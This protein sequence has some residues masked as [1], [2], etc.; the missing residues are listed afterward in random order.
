MVFAMLTNIIK[1]LNHAIG[2]KSGLQ[3]GDLFEICVH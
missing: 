1:F 2:E 3:S